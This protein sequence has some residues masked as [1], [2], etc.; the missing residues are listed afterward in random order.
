MSDSY[1]SFCNEQAKTLRRQASQPI[2]TNAHNPVYQRIDNTEL[3]AGLDLVATDSYAGAGNLARYAFEADWMRPLG[4]P[5][6]LLET[7][8]TH[9]GRTAVGATNSFAFFPGAVRAKMWLMYA[10][11]GEGVSFWLWQAHWAGQELEHGSL[12]YSWGD[13]CA[14][15]PEI[16]T[17]ARELTAH[18]DWLRAT[19]PKPA[20]VA[21]HYGLPMQW[22]FEASAIAAGFNYDESITA[23]H[24]L[25]VESGVA[26]DVISPHASVEGYDLVF[27]PYVPAF[28]AASLERLQRFVENGGTWVLGPLS[29]CRTPEVTAHRDACYGAAFEQWLGVHVRHRITPGGVTR[30]K[31]GRGG[32]GCRWWCDAYEA[33]RPDSLVQATY[34]GG[35]LHGLAAIVECPIA[36][37]RVI[38][39]GTLPDDTWLQKLMV[40]LAPR[41]RV[42]ADPGVVVV[43]RVHAA[44]QSAGFIAINTRSAEASYRIAGAVKKPLK[45][46]AV[47]IDARPGPGA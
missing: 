40:Q 16:R 37:G 24:R 33:S 35:P 15:T 5:F 30:L 38:L 22:Q 36:K 47:Q 10:L 3:F 19:Q 27:S 1:V 13:E 42:Q 14:T 29:A 43:E 4:K 25:L 45:G 23:F 17:V 46:Y 7:A 21:L 2:T 32:S 28:D 20:R 11:G 31:M 39:L 18:G 44:G 34:A 12:I 41:N 6:W 9:G 26:R 8:S